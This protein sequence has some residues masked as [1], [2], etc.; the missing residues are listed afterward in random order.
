MKRVIIVQARITSTRLPGKVLMDVAGKPMLVQQ[1]GRLK[2][3]VLADEIVI[4]T[5]T[6]SADNPL[7]DLARQEGVGWFR[8]DEHDVL[9][10]FVGAAR[11]TRADV[12]VRVTADCPLIDPQV[13]DQVIGELLTHTS[14]CDYASNVLQRTYPRGLD[15]EAFFL[16]TLLRMNRLA[17]FSQAREHVTVFLRSERPELFLCRSVEDEENNAD[18]RWTVDNAADLDLVRTLYHTLDLAVHPLSY[19]EV[20][21]HVRNHPELAAMNAKLDTWDPSR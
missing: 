9:S 13:S 4:A 5:T 10:R 2:Q 17:Q 8:G 19:H 7:V 6:N 15:V 14:E 18:L 11:Q 21:A 16:D 1:I 12:I 20:V 3:C